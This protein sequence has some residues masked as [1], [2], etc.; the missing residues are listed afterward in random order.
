[1]PLSP[2]DLKAA[3]DAIN[4]A[5]RLLIVP[6]ANVDPD[7]LSSALACY[8][9]FRE[10]GKDCTVICPET[11]PEN[12]D[13]LPSFEKL[14]TNLSSEQ[15]FII[16]LD[17]A[18]G[19]EVDK[20]RYTV[21]DHKVN[22]VV[23][24][25]KGRLTAKNVTLLESGLNYDLIVVLDSA[26]LT[27][28]G[29]MYTENIDLF[30]SIPVLNVDHHVSNT[31]YGQL[32]LIDPTAASATEVLYS[33][34]TAEPKWKDCINPDVATLLLTGLITD[35]RSFQNPNTTPKSLEVAAN[36]LDLG[37]RQQ[38]IIQ[39]IYKTKPLSTL[40][41][42]GRALN[43]IQI[44]PESRIVWSW[45][46]RED[47][48]EMGAKSQETHGLLDELISTVPDADLHIMFTEVEEGG[49]KASLRSSVAID[50]NVAAGKLF[51]GGGHSR[52][53]GF[54][55]K[56]YGNFQL[57]VIECI[58][59]LKDELT[60]QR[61]IADAALLPPVTPVQKPVPQMKPAKKEEAKKPEK[62]K[63]VDIVQT[64]G[65]ANGNQ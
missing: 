9:V 25:K 7:G 55:V 26:E 35:T 10:L 54:R 27:L 33:W 23:V 16:T 42:W 31:R 57:Q 41:I 43:R 15:E 14:S 6:H 19:V 17:L 65:S 4:K 63:G 3:T 12:L 24:P 18:N 37:A 62:T 20:L 40:R 49:M 48:G 38:E 11:P 5:E 53:S 60:R 45:I 22:I 34:F 64:L 28:L 56:N 32:Q 2:T 47:L 52:A 8:S 29:Q 50:A 51:G 44:D 58:K 36:L 1:M 30:S 39:H 59:Q 21:E 46:G 61:N 13:F